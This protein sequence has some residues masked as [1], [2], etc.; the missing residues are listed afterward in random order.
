MYCLRLLCRG[1]VLY[2]ALGLL[3]KGHIN[4]EI[5]R[6]LDGQ[7]DLLSK[8]LIYFLDQ[9]RERAS[10]GHGKRQ[11]VNGRCVF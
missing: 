11:S 8:W 5:D 6:H 1:K 9:F 4:L 3:R 2:G 7:K 10:V